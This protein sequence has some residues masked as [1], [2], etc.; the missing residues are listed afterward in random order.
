M[1]AQPGAKKSIRKQAGLVVLL[2][3]NE[4]DFRTIPKSRQIICRI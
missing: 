2:A 3:G 1:T 4:P